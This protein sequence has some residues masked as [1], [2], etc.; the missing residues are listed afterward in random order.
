MVIFLFL[1]QSLTFLFAVNS[2]YIIKN[3]QSYSNHTQYQDLARSLAKGQVY[4]DI[5]PSKEIK[6]MKNAYDY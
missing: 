2:N 4:L 1:I 5:E 6:S 3:L